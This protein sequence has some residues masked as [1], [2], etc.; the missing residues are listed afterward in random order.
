MV[1]PELELICSCTV[2]PAC[3]GLLSKEIQVV[4]DSGLMHDM[5]LQ[6]E[7]IRDLGLK[8]LSDDGVSR[9]ANGQSARHITYEQIRVSFF[10]SD[11]T[12]AVAFVTP[13]V[14]LNG[15]K[16]ISQN[17]ASGPELFFSDVDS[18]AGASEVSV[19]APEPS[20]VDVIVTPQKARCD[21]VSASTSETDEAYVPL[22]ARSSPPGSPNLLAAIVQGSGERLIG[23]RALSCLQLKLD[24]EHRILTRRVTL[25]RA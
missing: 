11:G 4:V 7:D 15:P 13:V 19:S 20:G 18:A 14:F 25:L 17:S 1:N 21:E 3:D 9:L 24:F 10:L 8:E 23:F 22:E 6:P 16:E 5:V 2:S 12:S